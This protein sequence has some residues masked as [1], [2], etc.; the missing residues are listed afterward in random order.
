[1]G[2]VHM[3]DMSGT[4]PFVLAFYAVT[5][6]SLGLF[7]LKLVRPKFPT[8]WLYTTCIV[9]IIGA[10]VVTWAF[11]DVQNKQLPQ[12]ENSNVEEEKLEPRMKEE[13]AMR[14]REVENQRYA[15]FWIIAI[16]NIV[17]LALGIFSDFNNRKRDPNKPRGRYD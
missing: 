11:D 9:G 14:R 8:Y 6:L 16:P 15:N 2:N 17:I 4:L 13:L 10:A 5:F 12:I 3:L 1:M 7:L